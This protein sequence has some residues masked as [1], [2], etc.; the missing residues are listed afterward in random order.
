M[1]THKKLERAALKV[2]GKYPYTK[3]ASREAFCLGAQWAAKAIHR[4]LFALTT[5]QYAK[6]ILD[7]AFGT[8]EGGKK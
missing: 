6:E 4:E 5:D 1:K 7:R 8:V 2:A 3:E